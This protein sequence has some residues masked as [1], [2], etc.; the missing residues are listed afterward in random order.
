MEKAMETII[1]GRGIAVRHD[2][3]KQGHGSHQTTMRA[4][5]ERTK[6]DIQTPHSFG[7]I[8]PLK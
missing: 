6:K 7:H 8:V 3:S 5:V 4:V 2:T 1:W